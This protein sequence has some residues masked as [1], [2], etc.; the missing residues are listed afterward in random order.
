MTASG[1]TTAYLAEH[2]SFQTKL[3]PSM[4][5]SMSGLMG[6]LVKPGQ[7]E[8]TSSIISK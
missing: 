8:N 3:L 6:W 5:Y 2:V 7:L 1:I 4:K